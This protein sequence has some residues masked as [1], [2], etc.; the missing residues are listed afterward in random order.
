MLTL[1]VSRLRLFGMACSFAI[2]IGTA[3]RADAGAIF[4]TGHDPDFHAIGHLGENPVGAQNINIAAIDFILDPLFNPFVADAPKFLFVE[5]KGAI[6]GG[7]DRGKTGIVASG[8]AEGVDFDHHDFTTLNAALDLLGD[9]GG[10]SGIVIAS[11]FGGI[12]R[13][14]ELDILNARKAD[15]ISFLNHGGGLY[16]MSEGNGGAEL[17]PGGGH[18]GFLPFVTTSINLDQS[19]SGNTVTPFGSSLGLTNNDVN[20]NFSHIVF[21]SNGPL[22]VVDRNA[23]GAVLSLAGRAQVSIPEPALTLLFG[24]ALLAFARLRRRQTNSASGR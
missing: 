6:P 23:A 1:P 10:Y 8:Y 24:V 3:A 12:L 2:A 11:D 21:T 14:A 22:Q 7:H 15:I 18:F 17:T 9:V 20:G 13:Q 4:L 16:A 5:S 19:E